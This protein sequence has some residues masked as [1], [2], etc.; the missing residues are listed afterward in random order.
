MLRT[1]N[2]VSLSTKV[3]KDE[4]ENREIIAHI[5]YAYGLYMY[6]IR[7]GRIDDY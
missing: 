7:R 2:L 4:T 5:V 3:G 6:Y 1:P